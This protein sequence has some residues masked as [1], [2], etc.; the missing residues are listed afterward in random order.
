MSR[1]C[2]RTACG[3]RCRRIASARAEGT[4]PATEGRHV[5]GVARGERTRGA[6]RGRRAVP[7]AAHARDAVFGSIAPTVVPA[8]TSRRPDRRARVRGRRRRRPPARPAR[9]PRR[10]RASDAR[11][12]A[13]GARRARVHARRERRSPRAGLAPGHPGGH[14]PAGGRRRPRRRGVVRALHVPQLAARD[15]HRGARR[16]RLD[17]AER[18]AQDQ[19][20]YQLCGTSGSA[21]QWRPPDVA[22]SIA[23]ARASAAIAAASDV[24]SARLSSSEGSRSTW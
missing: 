2:T 16:A 9:E 15:D 12:D 10:A 8:R 22:Y 11:A 4:D 20:L 19:A 7:R 14:D 24:S 1:G 5:R 3:R 13:P 18:G 21:H 23:L 6:R 17:R